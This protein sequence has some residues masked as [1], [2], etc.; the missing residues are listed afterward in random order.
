MYPGRR[1]F[2][3]T[4]W[5]AV[6]SCS[7][8][9]GRC[10]SPHVLRYYATRRGVDGHCPKR[11]CSAI[12]YKSFSM[13]SFSCLGLAK[14]ATILLVHLVVKIQ[15]VRSEYVGIMMNFQIALV[16]YLQIYVDSGGMTLAQFESIQF[17]KSCFVGPIV[18]NDLQKAS[19]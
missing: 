14:V 5:I 13:H 8:T 16:R 1:I 17:S 9:L 2:I 18:E 10:P 7:L 19:I 15:M 3:P 12:K 6:M 4:K 11:L